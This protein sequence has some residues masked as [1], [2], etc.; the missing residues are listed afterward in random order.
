MQVPVGRRSLLSDRAKFVVAV[1]GVALA[2]VLMLVVISLYEGVR[3]ETSAF[4]Q[5]MPGDI[6]ITQE[7]TT[8]LVFSNSHLPESA[9]VE[10]AEVEGA[11]G[12]D[13]LYGR[14]MS[15]TVQ[16]KHV[17]SYVLAISPDET[18]SRP[19]LEEFLP[20]SGTIILDSTF[21]QQTGISVGDT[22]SFAGEELTVSEIR[23]VGNLLVTQLSWVSAED[24]A[25][26][27]GISDTVSF[28]LVSTEDGATDDVIATLR[29]GSAGT[30][31][32][33]TEAFAGLASEEG[34]SSFLPIIRV[35][36]AIAFMVGISVLSLVVYSATIERARDYA[37][38]KVLGA[39]PLRLYRIVLGQST[40]IATLGVVIGIGLTFLF[41]SIA[42]DLVPQF[43]TYVRFQD[44]VFVLAFVAIMTL[45]S[46]FMP[47]LRIARVEPATVFRA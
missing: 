7:G 26:L 32:Y 20:E 28:I 19:G 39:S 44:V 16:G 15:F 23:H 42:G 24:F 40:I 36:V 18:L 6:W 2:I 12:V 46:S 4:I 37:I 43:I 11:I 30:S 47:V 5:S 25:R 27:F 22:L 34:V 13:R 10:A 31:V 17:R 41:N 38:M 33:T 29:E 9:A 14:M 3:R 45:L 8:D 35:L 21:V 1:G